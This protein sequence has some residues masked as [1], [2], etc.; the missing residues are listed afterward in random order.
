MAKREQHF[1]IE[2]KNSWPTPLGTFYKIPDARGGKFILSKPYDVSATYKNIPLAIEGKTLKKLSAINYNLLEDSQK[3]ALEEFEAY[4]G[5]IAIIVVNIRQSR[6]ILK[7]I[8]HIN[9]MYYFTHKEL[10]TVGSIHVKDL[11]RYPYIEGHK[12]LF[13]LKNFFMWVENILQS[14]SSLL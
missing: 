9:R 14:G 4:E 2:L 10:K 6:D 13:D 1:L 11:D 8:P 7:D 5:R 3:V 12:K